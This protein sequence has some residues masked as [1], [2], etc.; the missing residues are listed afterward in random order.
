MS[1]DGIEYQC[2]IEAE[3]E[4][5]QAQ[6]LR[7]KNQDPTR[8]VAKRRRFTLLEKM[9]AVRN[10]QRNIEVGHISIRLACKALNLHH[11][12]FI[13]WKRDIEVMQAKRNK[14]AKSMCIGPS[15]ILYPFEEPLL[16]Y[17]FE[18]RE[19]GIA[20]STRLVVIKAASFSRAFREKTQLAQYSSARRFLVRHGLVHQMGTLLSE[21]DPRELEQTSLQFLECVQPIVT[22]P[23]RDQDFIIN[24]DQFPIL[25]D[26]IV[27]ID[28]P[29]GD[30]KCATL[31]VTITASGRILTPVL[32]F[33][34]K[35]DG[36]IPT[37]DFATYPCGC[38]YTCQNSAWMDEEVM[39]LWVEKVLKPYILEAP[40][41]VVPLLLLD[42]FRCH[43][44]ASVVT[45]INELG[46]EVQHIPGRC[47]AFCKPVDVGVAKPLK[48]ML[49][50]QW[51]SWVIEEEKKFN[52]MTTDTQ[53][54]D[55]CDS[56]TMELPKR[57]QIAMW[58]VKALQSIST[59]AVWNSWRHRNFSWF[60]EETKKT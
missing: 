45:R 47:T 51:E 49:R 12:Q 27:H 50:D 4:S 54:R 43:M 21:R 26:Q 6:E 56:R 41:H 23:G 60:P 9:A 1:A 7:C 31:A 22:G 28:K 53:Q 11:K 24:M 18:L 14:K 32:V 52:E 5:C 42:S 37:Q 34:G 57:Q 36:Q 55:Q 29:T 17:I 13:T 10:I 59:Q 40:V 39:L 3:E 33:K 20:V 48:Y 15:S 38:I 46:V 30:T 19:Q 25:G 58:T 8:Q 16:R 44:M 2:K 35:P